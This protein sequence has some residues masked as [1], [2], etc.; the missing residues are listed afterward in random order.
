MFSVTRELSR[1]FF[2]RCAYSFLANVDPVDVFFAEHDFNPET[3]L[4]VIISKT[5]TTAETL[6]NALT[7]RQWF[8]D[9][10]RGNEAAIRELSFCRQSVCLSSF[11]VVC[12]RLTCRSAG[13]LVRV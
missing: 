5:F 11:E 1:L 13:N 10:Y 3:T 12:A 2:L 7:L 6:L 9:Y 4:V 8:S